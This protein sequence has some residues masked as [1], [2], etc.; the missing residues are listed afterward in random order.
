MSDRIR[1]NA[2]EMRTFIAKLFHRLGVPLADAQMAADVLVTADLRGV[3]VMASTT[4][5]ST[6]MRFTRR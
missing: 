5:G 3:K 2:D 4:C 1:I 6:Q